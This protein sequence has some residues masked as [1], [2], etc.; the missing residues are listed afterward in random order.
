MN[1]DVLL[2]RMKLTLL[3]STPSAIHATL[4]PAPVK[5]SERAVMADG[6]VESVFVT[7]SA[8]GSS[9]TAAPH[10]PGITLGV[11]EGAMLGVTDG[12]PCALSP[13]PVLDTPARPA[14]HRIR[15]HECNRG[16]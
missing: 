13:A 3:G 8:S 12:P 6:S 10:A 4:T 14:H 1:A 11:R 16:V 2:E 5:P 9:S 7:C 15:N